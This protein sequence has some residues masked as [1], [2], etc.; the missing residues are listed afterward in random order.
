MASCFVVTSFSCSH[1][2]YNPHFAKSFVDKSV[3]NGCD[4]VFIVPEPRTVAI[5]EC[6]IS[7]CSGKV[8]GNCEADWEKPPTT[9]IF[10]GASWDLMT[11]EIKSHETAWSH[12][13][14]PNDY[15]DA[16]VCVISYYVNGDRMS[17][18]GDSFHGA[19]IC[20]AANLF[21]RSLNQGVQ[22]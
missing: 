16:H 9:L 10:S 4:A 3:K 8:E 18:Y 15:E 17:Y 12:F 7:N 14:A 6:A 20:E 13:H 21:A 1:V 22:P 2:K 19:A 5:T 11:T